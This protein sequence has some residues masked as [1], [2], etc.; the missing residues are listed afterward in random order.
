MYKLLAVGL[1]AGCAAV[2][3]P[4]KTTENMY[5]KLQR[6][7]L[8]RSGNEIVEVGGKFEVRHN[9]TLVDADCK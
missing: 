2:K 7:T 4:T 8:V 5:D 9:P 3:E 6:C 1:L